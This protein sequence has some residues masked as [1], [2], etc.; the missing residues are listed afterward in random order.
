[1][2][3]LSAVAT[4]G[5]ALLSRKAAKKAAKTQARAAESGISEQRL[6]REQAFGALQPF[7]QAGEAALD[8][9][10]RFVTEGPETEFERTQGF[11]A[12]QKS[13][14]AGRK[15]QSGETLQAL[16]EFSAG[17]NQR[18]R[19]Q[20]FNE[21]LSLANLGQ[22]SAAGTANIG[23][24]SGESV[25]NLLVGQGNV[26]AAGTVGASNALQTGITQFGSFLGSLK[27][28]APTV[29]PVPG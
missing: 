25:S 22:T 3:I 20:R 6:A 21:L 5:G 11:E 24:R 2:A 17:V 13:A 7:R 14:A 9:L 26:R 12:I 19:N 16:T 27:P 15:L 8:P 29:Q 28:Q 1:M 10:Q 18:F 4:V 23:L